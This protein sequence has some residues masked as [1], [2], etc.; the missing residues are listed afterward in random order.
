MKVERD[1]ETRPRSIP[2]ANPANSCPNHPPLSLSVVV[3]PA[4]A[5]SHLTRYSLF[6]MMDTANPA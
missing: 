4:P 1:G 6:V 2:F 5:Y 3:S